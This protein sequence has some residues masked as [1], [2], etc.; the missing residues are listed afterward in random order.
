MPWKSW[1]VRSH[2][3]EREARADGQMSSRDTGR[4]RQLLMVHPGCSS[5]QAPKCG[6]ANMAHISGETSG[7]SGILN[8]RHCP[9]SVARQADRMMAITAASLESG[10]R[11]GFGTTVALS[12]DQPAAGTSG[13]P[14][15][16]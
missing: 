10:R 8:S 7:I 5:A 16:P 15:T 1:R 9:G 11:D 4:Q 13:P 12:L 2:V 6:G 14:F 3:R